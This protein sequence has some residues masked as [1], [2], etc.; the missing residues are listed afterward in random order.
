MECSHT[1][2]TQG[3]NHVYTNPDQTK[4]ACPAVAPD[5]QTPTVPA[6][7]FQL[8]VQSLH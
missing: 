5:T 7:L 8:A 2:E 4:A 1:S 3:P 6:L